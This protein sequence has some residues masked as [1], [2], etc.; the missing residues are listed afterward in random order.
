MKW[1]STLLLF[2][3]VITL[4]VYIRFIDREEVSTAQQNARRTRAFLIDVNS[5]EAI[6]IEKDSFI[7]KCSK[8]HG[9]WMMLQPVHDFADPQSIEEFLIRLHALRKDTVITKAERDTQQLP[10]SQYG[11]D[12]PTTT[13]SIV[14]RVRTRTYRIGRPTATGRQVFM[15]DESTQDVVP[16]STNVLQLIPS[17]STTWRNH[18]LFCNKPRYVRS[19]AMKRREGYIQLQRDDANQWMLLQPIK[20]RCNNLV[21]DKL[22]GGVYDVRIQQFVADRVGDPSIYGLSDEMN[23]ISFIPTESANAFTLLVGNPVKDNPGLVY[24]KWESD[25]SIYAVTNAISRLLAVPT[26]AIRNRQLVSI[27][28]AMINRITIESGGTLLLFSKE[29]DDWMLKKPISQRVEQQLVQNL[30]STWTK[31]EILQFVNN[32]V[33]NAKEY[34]IQPENTRIRFESVL[35]QITTNDTSVKKTMMEQTFTASTTPYENDMLSLLVS[36]TESVVTV[37]SSLLTDI[38]ANPLYYR[39]HQLFDYASSNIVKLSVMCGT[40]DQTVELR[41]GA[42]VMDVVSPVGGTLQTNQLNH[43]LK[44]LPNL[45]ASRFI[46]MNPASLTPYGLDTPQATITMSLTGDTAIGKT[47]LLGNVQIGS[48]D[49]FAM[50]RGLDIVFTLPAKVA[51]TLT[52]PLVVSLEHTSDE[53]ASSS[54][55]RP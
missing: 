7:L 32:T 46:A 25:E 18:E 23:T 9:L 24:V 13:L 26:E 49:I 27:P 50:I 8:D 53:S 55:P 36:P 54:S 31:A 43:I 20:T 51:E 21:V 38:K 29:A 28:P 12:N 17:K 5:V 48:D 39:N 33:T 30:I 4:G 37:P 6:T 1:R 40:T 3:V 52:Q 35:P 45:R 2:V 10:L 42:A 41:S 16:V 15:M 47:L 19:L 22:F 34:G 11:L 14:D 44:L